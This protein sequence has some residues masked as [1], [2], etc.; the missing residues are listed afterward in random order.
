M[1]GVALKSCGIARLTLG[2]GQRASRVFGTPVSSGFRGHIDIRDSRS[3]KTENV[4]YSVCECGPDCRYLWGNAVFLLPILS[5]ARELHDHLGRRPTGGATRYVRRM[6]AGPAPGRGAEGCGNSGGSPGMG[7][8]RHRF[9]QPGANAVAG[10]RPERAVKA[11]PTRFF[12]DRLRR[13]D[14]VRPARLVFRV[15]RLRRAKVVLA[16]WPC[17][18]TVSR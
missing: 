8:R 10:R 18:W 2:T 5:C 9:T 13:M 3:Q 15:S 17:S 4:R 16:G 11:E 1:A 12:A 7:V 14:L 6:P